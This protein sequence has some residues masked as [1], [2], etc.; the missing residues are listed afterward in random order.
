MNNNLLKKFKRQEVYA[1]ILEDNKGNIRFTKSQNEITELKNKEDVLI[2]YNPNKNT[3]EKL[4]KIM[5][6]NLNKETGL[7]ELKGEDVILKIIPLL[8]NVNLIESENP[9]DEELES[10]REIIQDPTELFEILVNLVKEQISNIYK[11]A[12]EG[13]EALNNLDEDTKDKIIKDMMKEE[14]KKQEDI[15]NI[16]KKKKEKEEL[17]KKIKMLEEEGI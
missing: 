15:E 10:I 12:I 16:N 14:Y 8:T 1:V 9:T 17:Q 4:F 6:D 13:L 7:L 3:K 11:K 2:V 5:I